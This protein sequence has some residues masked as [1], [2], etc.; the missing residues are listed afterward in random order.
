MKIKLSELRQLI[1]SVI[2]EQS[3]TDPNYP[4]MGGA[5]NL[6]LQNGYE[7]DN[8]QKGTRNDSIILSNQDKGVTVTLKSDPNS[9]SIQVNMNGKMGEI[10]KFHTID[11]RDFGMATIALGLD[12]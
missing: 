8:F 6:F 9:S 11:D 10:K 12:R 5:T 1:K 3:L 4:V 7:V 2:I